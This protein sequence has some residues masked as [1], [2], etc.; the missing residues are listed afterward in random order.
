MT[1]IRLMPSRAGEAFSLGLMLID[2]LYGH[3]CVCVS[4]P[5]LQSCPTLCS[6]VDG[7]PPSSSVRGI[8]QARILE[9]VAMSSSRGSSQPWDRTCSSCTADRFFTAAPLGKP[10]FM[11][12]EVI[13]VELNYCQVPSCWNGF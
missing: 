2:C 4:A 11:E 6:P 9:W 13:S 10:I 3:V 5:L 12:F 1:W 8:L 7:S